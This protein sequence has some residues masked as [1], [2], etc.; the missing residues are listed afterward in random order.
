ML[1]DK[2]LPFESCDKC[3][4]FILKVDEQAIFAE[5]RHIEVVLKIRC[6]NEYLCKHLKQVLKDE[7]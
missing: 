5:D 6:K 2:C 4:E 3:D 7:K 1:I